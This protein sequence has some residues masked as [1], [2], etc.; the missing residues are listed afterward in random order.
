MGTNAACVMPVCSGYV[1]TVSYE[2]LNCRPVWPSRYETAA[3]RS[4]RSHI[5]LYAVHTDIWIQERSNVRLENIA[6]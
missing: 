4:I 6:G 1:A 2:K 3:M 5:E